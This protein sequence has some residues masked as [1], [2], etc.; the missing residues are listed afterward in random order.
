MFQ[1]VNKLGLNDGIKAITAH[2]SQYAMALRFHVSDKEFYAFN[3]S[4]ESNGGC[5]VSHYVDG[6]NAYLWTR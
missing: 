4:L 3:M 5:S 1:A 2:R 6:K